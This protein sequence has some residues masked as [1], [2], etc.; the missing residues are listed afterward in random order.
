LPASFTNCFA[1]TLLLG[2]LSNGKHLFMSNV[3]DMWHNWTSRLVAVV[4]ILLLQLQCQIVLIRGSQWEY[5]RE[6]IDSAG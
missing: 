2:V 5:F 3:D 1:S 4:K 6:F